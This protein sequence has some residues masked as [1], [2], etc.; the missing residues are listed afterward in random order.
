[1]EGREKK[2]LEI[3]GNVLGEIKK[4]TLLKQETV[5]KA[6]KEAVRSIK[7]ELPEEARTV[8]VMEYIIAEMHE[9]VKQSKIV[10]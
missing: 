9:F 1:M 6:V 8:E 5:N 7:N 10:L 4:V 3:T 2:L